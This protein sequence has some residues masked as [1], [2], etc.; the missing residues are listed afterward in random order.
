MNFC[1]LGI[2]FVMPVLDCISTTGGDFEWARVN[3]PG[4]GNY[5]Q[6]VNDG[7]SKCVQIVEVSS[8]SITDTRQ[9]LY[10]LGRRTE[11]RDQSGTVLARYYDLGQTI[12]GSS[13]YYSRD[14]IRSVRELTDATGNT[15]AMQSYDPFGR[16]SKLVGNLVSD[17]QFGDYYFHVRSGL[18]LARNRSYSPLLGRW[19]NRDP[20]K[21]TSNLYV[22]VLNDPIA[23][24]D[25]A[26]TTGMMPQPNDPPPKLCIGTPFRDCKKAKREAIQS[27]VRTTK[28]L[29]I[30]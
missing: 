7:M 10:A 17:F 4:T 6:F 15:Q 20:M 11:T 5:S 22:Y 24:I 19:L 2:K 27:V 29:A 18:S 30:P 21:G 23:L 9:F 1:T 16:A 12:S 26:G 3:Y 14:N 25:P 28:P 13:Y 8:G